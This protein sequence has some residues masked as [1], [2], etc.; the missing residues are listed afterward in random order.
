[1]HQYFGP[2][3]DLGDGFSGAVTDGVGR[4]QGQ[5]ARQLKVQLHKPD[6]ARDPGTQVVGAQH[7]GHGTGQF[8]H[9]LA[10]IGG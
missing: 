8:E 3:V 2:W 1:M 4:G 7:A 10:D 5:L 9:V 6:I